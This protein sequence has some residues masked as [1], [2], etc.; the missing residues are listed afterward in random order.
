MF[1]KAGREPASDPESTSGELR[2][3]SE[4]LRW[5]DGGQCLELLDSSSS[6][7]NA[8]LMPTPLTSGTNAMPVG[9]KRSSFSR[10]VPTSRSGRTS[11]LTWRPTC[12][13]RMG[14]SWGPPSHPQH[15]VQLPRPGA[16]GLRASDLPAGA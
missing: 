9:R 1:P 16:P 4:A 10:W 13:R 14:R 7:C 11:S 5:K 2:L 8:Y 6:L 15:C 3:L 12:P